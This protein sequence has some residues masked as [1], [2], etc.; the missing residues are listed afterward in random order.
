MGSGV[1]RLRNDGGLASKNFSGLRLLK[2][3]RCEKDESK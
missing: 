3:A 1:R 2:F